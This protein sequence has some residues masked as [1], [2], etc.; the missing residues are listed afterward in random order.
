ME[1]D[2]AK[3]KNL[4]GLRMEMVEKGSM[5]QAEYDKF[6]RG[7]AAQ[8]AELN[9]VQGEFKKKHESLS[10]NGRCVDGAQFTLYT[11]NDPDKP[12][13][14]EDV[15]KYTQ[16]LSK[17][18]GVLTQAG[19][20]PGELPESDVTIPGLR[21]ATFRD[22]DVGEAAENANAGLNYQKPPEWLKDQYRDTDFYKLSVQAMASPIP[23]IQV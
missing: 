10:S 9:F 16:F 1:L 7:V 4:H 20:Q 2:L 19:I 6:G 3:A 17:L 15:K 5:T 22:E 13:K 11:Q 12:W 21:F 18:E 14:A 8:E 23:A